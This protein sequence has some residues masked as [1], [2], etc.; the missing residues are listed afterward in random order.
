MNQEKLSIFIQL[1][2][3]AI[4][5]AEERRQIMRTQE[6]SQKSKEAGWITQL[7]IQLGK[8]HIE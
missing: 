3:K 5:I 6:F 1:I 8:E 2:D 4:R 7:D